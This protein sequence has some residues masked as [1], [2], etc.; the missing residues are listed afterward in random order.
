M[1]QGHQHYRTPGP[2]PIWCTPGELEEF[3]QITTR[4]VWNIINMELHM[5]RIGQWWEFDLKCNIGSTVGKFKAVLVASV[6]ANNWEW[7]A[8]TMS[9]ISFHL[10]LA[11]ACLNF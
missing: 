4:E 3:N 8:P 2:S 6:I 10:V 9:L 7:I 11:T 5:K 1:S